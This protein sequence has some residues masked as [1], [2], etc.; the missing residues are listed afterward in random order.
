[1]SE[2]LIIILN[3]ETT[4][5]YLE[6]ASRKTNAEVDDAC[7]PSGCTLTIE[8]APPFINTVYFGG[9]EIGEAYV[10]LK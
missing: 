10:E 2:K 8:I 6:R 3:E 1:M 9:D 4:R 5:K 7:V